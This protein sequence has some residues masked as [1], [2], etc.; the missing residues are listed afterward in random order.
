MLK[1][2]TL[3]LLLKFQKVWTFE[4][5]AMYGALSSYRLVNLCYIDFECWTFLVQVF[6]FLIKTYSVGYFQIYTFIRLTV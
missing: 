5:L 4:Y 2:E 6:S 1:T 3:S